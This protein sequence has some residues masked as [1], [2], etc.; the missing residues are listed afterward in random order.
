MPIYTLEKDL[1]S[2]KIR[3]DVEI[4]RARWLVGDHF[5]EF[6]AYS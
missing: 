3:F 6:G 4:Q 1:F 2:L 5:G